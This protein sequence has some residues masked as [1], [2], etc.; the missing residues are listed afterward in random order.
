MFPA[1][2]IDHRND[3]DLYLGFL[4]L[5]V[6]LPRCK[7]DLYVSG[8][9]LRLP[10]VRLLML[11]N[12]G[13]FMSPSLLNKFLNIEDLKFQLSRLEAL[14][15]K[16]ETANLVIRYLTSDPQLQMQLGYVLQKAYDTRAKV[17]ARQQEL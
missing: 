16:P 9:G 1:S 4:S 3:I 11:R 8:E 13:P 14:A 6:Y 15:E 17:R 10:R 5:I 2:R 7:P 12:K